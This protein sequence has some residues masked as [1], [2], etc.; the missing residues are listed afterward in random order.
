MPAV[1]KRFFWA[2]EDK[3]KVKVGRLYQA[4]RI[5]RGRTLARKVEVKAVRE[6]LDGSLAHLVDWH[7][8]KLILEEFRVDAVLF[9]H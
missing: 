5:E 4:G 9:I 8:V 7:E 1:D 6:W 2:F 3:V